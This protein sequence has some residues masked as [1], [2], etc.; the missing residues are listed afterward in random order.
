M[1]KTKPYTTTNSY[2]LTG[3]ATLDVGSGTDSILAK[4][5]EFFTTEFINIANS[6]SIIWEINGSNNGF[7]VLK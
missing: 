5:K 4:D 6:E 1:D 7:P 2:Y 3:T